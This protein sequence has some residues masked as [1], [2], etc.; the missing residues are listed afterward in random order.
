MEFGGLVNPADPLS[1]GKV[2]YYK[3]G[4]D[5]F[6]VLDTSGDGTADFKLQIH[7]T[8]TLTAGEFLF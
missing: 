3:Q 8:F 4:G 6:V 2:G 1:V 5:T 7:G